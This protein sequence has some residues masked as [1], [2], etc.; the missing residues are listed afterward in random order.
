MIGLIRDL[1]SLYGPPG[2]E[3]DV[4]QWLVEY[5]NKRGITHEVDPKGNVIA[6][7]GKPNG[8]PPILVTAHMDEIALMITRI[9][10]DGSISVAP[11]G[12]VYTW[13]WGE[14]LVEILTSGGPI[15]A[16]V[17]YGCIHTNHPSSVVEHA[18][19][20]PLDWSMAS[21]FTGL[22][23]A[24]LLRQG[25]RPGLRVVLDRSRRT[26]TELGDHIASWFLDDR[27]DIAVMLKAMETITDEDNLG[28]V[29]FAATASEEVGGEGACAILHRT[30]AEICVALEIGPSTPDAPISI[31]D[32]PS[33]WVKDGYASMQSEDGKIL[34]ECA[35]ELGQTP[36]WLFL[37][38]GGSDAS[39]AAHLGLTSRPVTLAMPTENSHGYEIMHKDAPSEVVRLLLAYLRKVS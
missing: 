9:E 10:P 13:K 38:R 15:Q 18:R 32:Q 28:H 11:L 8:K 1:V 6:T 27:A 35:H 30:R 34:E 37:S 12:G 2:E 24:Q 21:L 23:R 16:V 26:V 29:M 20:H 17:S 3:G 5:Y 39:C 7:V 14:G 36:P 22:T 31:D 4:T 25:V 19:N 33:I